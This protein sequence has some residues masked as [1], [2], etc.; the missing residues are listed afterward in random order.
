MIYQCIVSLNST[1]M[2][3]CLLYKS[4][5]GLFKFFATWQKALS[6]KGAGDIGELL[7][8]EGVLLPGSNVFPWQVFV[9]QVASPVPGSSST[10]SNPLTQLLWPRQL[11]QGSV[12]AASPA[13]HGGQKSQVTIT[14]TCSHLPVHYFWTAFSHSLDGRSPAS[15]TSTAPQPFLCHSTNYSHAFFNKVGFQ[16]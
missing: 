3:Y 2:F 16:P 12:P 9:E 5:S 8:E 11:L 10:W 13:V 7:Q 6:V 15:S 4:G 14:S 1:F